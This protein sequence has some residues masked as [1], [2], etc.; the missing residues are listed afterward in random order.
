M[1]SAPLNSLDL[2][3]NGLNEAAKKLIRDACA[4]KKGMSLQ[5]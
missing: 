3:F 1:V 4:A 5:L 2:Q